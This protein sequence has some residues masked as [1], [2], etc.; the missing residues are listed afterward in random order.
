MAQALGVC[1]CIC[2]SVA[3]FAIYSA[4]AVL[5]PVEI[6]LDY[7][8]IMQTISP[9]AWGPGRHW[10]GIGHTFVKF[11]STVITVSFTHDIKD[12]SG[13]PLRSRTA[14]G[15]EVELEISFQYQ[16]QQDT[17][18]GMYTTF[19]DGYHDLF[20]KMGMDIL[21]V[22]ATKHPAKD[23]F[24]NRTMI[25][26]TMEDSLRSHFKKHAKVEVPLFQ[27]QAVSLPKD[28]EIAIRQTQVAEQKIKRMQANQTMRLVEF[29]T[30]VIQAQRYVQVRKQQANAVAESIALA[31][32]AEIKKLNATQLCAAT[33]FQNMLKV[34]EGDTSQ[35]LK[36]M[37][38]RAVRDHPSQ[39]SILGIRDDIDVP[40]PTPSI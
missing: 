17:L 32:A 10:I 23:F 8:M 40:T 24:V 2:A 29:Q 30:E 20:V 26:N 5:E 6:G 11:Q 7:N 9:D 3:L 33:A 22:A 27:F 19:G 25:G 15:L 38:V 34:F 21:T 18:H 16:L 39:R 13:A 4:W 35:L 1:A 28:F 12:S 37:K 36:Y 31:N 14:D